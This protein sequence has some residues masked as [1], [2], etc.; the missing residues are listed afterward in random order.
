METIYEDDGL[1]ISSK[2]GKELALKPDFYLT[3]IEVAIGGII[4]LADKY[5]DSKENFM[6][7]MSDDI[8]RRANCMMQYAE[9]K[10]VGGNNEQP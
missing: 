3:L 2:V 6:R 9:P 8:I 7:L 1:V 5:V 10:S 4:Q